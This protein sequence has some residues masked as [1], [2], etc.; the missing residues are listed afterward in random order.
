MWSDFKK[1][2]VNNAFKEESERINN[3][4][5][6]DNQ[7]SYLYNIKQLWSENK[8]NLELINQVKPVFASGNYLIITHPYDSI[9]DNIN[10]SIEHY[11][12]QLRKSNI[13]TRLVALNNSEWAIAKEKWLYNKTSHKKYNYI[14][15][16]FDEELEKLVEEIEE[17]LKT[18]NSLDYS[19]LK[20]LNSCKDFNKLKENLFFDDLIQI[21]DILKKWEKWEEIHLEGDVDDLL[22]GFIL[23]YG[24]ECIVNWFEGKENTKDFLN[25]FVQNYAIKGRKYKTNNEIYNLCNKITTEFSK[26]IDRDEKLLAGICLNDNISLPHF[27]FV[28]KCKSYKDFITKLEKSVDVDNDIEVLSF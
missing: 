23:N 19:K 10:D 12:E 16:P 21:E 17:D 8:F 18:V 28:N 24:H 25:E 2:R 20:I 26:E 13:K 4:S 15:D 11:E 5:E 1:I 27:Y 3:L 7:T 9:V 14:K 22:K 6:E